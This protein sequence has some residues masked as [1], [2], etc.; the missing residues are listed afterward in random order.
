M[1]SML[2]RLSRG[3]RTGVAVALLTVGSYAAAQSA[4]EHPDT[5]VVVRGDT[6]W[7][8]AGKFL[9]R[10]WLWPEIWQANP[11]IQN[12]HLIYPGDVISL[13]YLNRVAVDPGPRQEAPINVIPLS[14]IEA[15]LKNRSIVDGF[16][17]LPHVVGIEDSRLR[18]SPEQRIYATGLDYA[19]TGERYAIVRPSAEFYRSP[20]TRDL[21]FRGARINGDTNL[22]TELVPRGRDDAFLGYEITQM[23]VASVVHGPTA[24]SPLTVLSLDL[25]GL[26]VRAGDRLVPVNPQPYDLQFFPHPPSDHA[27][28]LGAQVIAVADTV[29]TGGPRDVIA[30]SAGSADGVDNGTVFSIWRN[31]PHTI[32]RVRNPNTSRHTELP[33]AGGSRVRMPDEYAAHAMVFRTF[34][35]VS[36][37]LVMEGTKPARVGYALKHPD[38]PY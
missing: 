25:E 16:D 24:V 5:Y 34:D 31:G 2:E 13:A 11:Q 7:D 23:A 8:I 28:A 33:N 37:A 19:Q 26:E 9:Q 1:A 30:I 36:Y 4:R 3:L 17:H 10:P 6:L 21:D 22:W 38:A 35:N 18:G 29:S 15:F 20:R 12:P 27:L 14:D 32:D